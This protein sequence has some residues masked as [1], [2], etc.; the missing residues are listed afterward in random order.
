MLLDSYKILFLCACFCIFGACQ[1]MEN[2]IDIEL[3][4]GDNE[5]VVECY[6]E[7]GQPYRLMLT[8]T[9][10]YFEVTNICPFVRHA[11]VVITHNNQKDT[12]KEAPYT[13]SACSS[14]QPYFSADSTRIF[15]YGSTTVCP[16]DFNNEFKLEVWDTINNRQI[17]ATTTFIPPEPI[18]RFEFEW[19]WLD[20][21]VAYC[22]LGCKNN[23]ATSDYYRMTLHKGTLSRYN[24]NSL[25]KYTATNPYFDQVMYDQDIFSGNEVFHASGYN[26]WRTD[27]VIG[28]IYHIDKAYYDYLVTSRRAEEANL[29][30]FVES[31][32]ILS[33]IQ[34]GHG[35]FTFLSYDRDTVYIPW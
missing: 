9:K 17:E 12:L 5:L 21:S 11:I 2:A 10:S 6:L 16:L 33:N 32:I 23:P 1:K 24:P 35:I 20:D 22:I 19:T 27:T 25:F 3:E 14:I 31:S 15:N 26:F 28:T 29:N 13:S 7:A 30:P 8:E 18:T 4:D 34:G